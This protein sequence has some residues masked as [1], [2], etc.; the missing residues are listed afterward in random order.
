[1]I[2]SMTGFGAAEGLLADG[3]L[4][5]VEIRTVNHRHLNIHARSPTGWEALEKPVSDAVRARLTRGHVTVS[6]AF[7]RPDGA[8]SGLPEVDMERV[9]HYVEALGRIQEELPVGGTLDVN[10]LAR[11]PDVFRPSRQSAEAPSPDEVLP[12][13]DEALDGVVDMRTREGTRLETE[14]RRSLARIG[15]ELDG[16]ES[17]A[18]ARLVRERDRLRQQVQALTEAVDVDEDRLAREIAYLAEKWDIQEELVRFRSHIALFSETLAPEREERAGKRLGFVVQ[19]MNRE[20]NTIGSKAN[21]PDIAA[22]AV[23]IKEQLEQLREQLE[24]VE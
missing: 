18:P 3:Q 2:R 10:A 12:V 21:D 8:A 1:M 13:V 16:I 17:L 9:R 14:I 5:R 11:F 20:A 4:L 24:N 22:G 6:L 23:A 7:D 19:E 15:E